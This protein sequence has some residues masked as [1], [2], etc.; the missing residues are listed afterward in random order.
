MSRNEWEK[1]SFVVPSSEWA[2]LKKKIREADGDMRARAYALAC[3]IHAELSALPAAERRKDNTDRAWDFMKRKLGE[4]AVEDERGEDVRSMA[5]D[6]VCAR[7]YDRE[8]RTTVHSV[9]RPKKGDFAPH[10]NNVLRFDTQDC[11]I[12]FDNETRTVHWTVHEN[13]HAVERARASAIGTALFEAFRTMPWTR[14]T[15]G[16]IVGND[17]Y[18][19][20]AGRENGFGGGTYDKDGFGP[21]GGETDR[22]RV[23]TVSVF[24]GGGFR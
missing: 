12:E 23:E 21:K 16:T 10:G 9:T 11:C 18:N 24:R 5:V 6:A 22:S 17:E 1:G 3:G 14:G 4:R 13:N 2:A 15:G 20:D 19:E 8:K 7:S